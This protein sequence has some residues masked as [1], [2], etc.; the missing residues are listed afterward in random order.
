MHGDG[1]W[2]CWDQFS[3]KLVLA[4]GFVL[5]RGHEIS[6]GFFLRNLVPSVPHKKCAHHTTAKVAKQQGKS[7]S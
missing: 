2:D 6:E 4:K 1:E 5:W 7:A 3:E